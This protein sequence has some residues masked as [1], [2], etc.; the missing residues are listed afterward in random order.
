MGGMSESGMRWSRKKQEPRVTLRGLLEPPGSFD[1]L[2]SVGVA[3]AGPLAMWASSEGRESLSEHDEQPGWASFPK[4]R[5]S[6]EPAVAL[7]AYVESSAPVDTVTLASMPVAFPHI[8]RLANGS[9]LLVGSRCKWT[10]E[11]P[12]LNA[13]VVARDG[14]IERE[15]CL[16]DGLQHVQVARDGTIW[17]GYFDEGIFGNYGWGGVD[18]PTPLGAAGIAAWSPALTKTWELDP[19][20]GLVSDCYALNVTSDFVWIC[21]YTDFPVVRIADRQTKVWTTI[22]I[23]GPR[24][25]LVSGERVALIGSYADPSQLVV[26]HMSGDQF[27]EDLRTHLRSPDGSTLAASTLHC[28]GSVAHFF[29]DNVWSTFDLNELP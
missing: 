26:G 16:G 5:S 15:G 28:S 29:R 7:T 4:S 6:S 18:G 2:V 20:Q 10:T 11:G 3:F 1:S 17:T 25:I 8:Q 24:G 23:S 19:T 9:F 14:T 12:E 21:P 13:L 22:D 27:V